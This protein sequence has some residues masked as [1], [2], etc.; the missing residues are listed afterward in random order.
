MIKC[1]FT[2]SKSNNQHLGLKTETKATTRKEIR[3]EK[4]CKRCGLE[5]KKLYNTKTIS[6]FMRGMV[7]IDWVTVSVN[8]VVASFVCLLIVLI[9]FEMIK[10][11]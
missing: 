7:K 4:I 10:K 9:T 1:N 6:P 2:E 3:K 11:K 5:A 8:M